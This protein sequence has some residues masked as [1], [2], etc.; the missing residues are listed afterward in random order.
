MMDSSIGRKQ[1][2]LSC[3]II[4]AVAGSGKTTYIKSVAKL[5]ANLGLGSYRVILTAFNR[6][7]AADLNQVAIDIGPSLSGFVKMGGS[8]TVQAAGLSEIIAPAGRQRGVDISVDK[9][10]ER[11]LARV[12]TADALGQYVEYDNL[13]ELG[14]NDPEGNWISAW[15]AHAN[16]L[17]DFVSLSKTMD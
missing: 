12:V 11:N 16:A 13:L 17:E 2:S 5:M 1:E 15:Y 3:Q 10:K 9:T 4:E 6:H 8:N 7:I 14:T